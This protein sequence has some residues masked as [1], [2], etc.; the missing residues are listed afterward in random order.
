[1]IQTYSISTFLGASTDEEILEPKQSIIEKINNYFKDSSKD[2]DE[3]I[4]DGGD[5]P[6]E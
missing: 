5:D 2:G 3:E 4:D 1:M 6:G